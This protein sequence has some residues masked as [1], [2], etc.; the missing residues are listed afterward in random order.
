MR[1]LKKMKNYT[2]IPHM[3]NGRLAVHFIWDQSH[4]VWLA[5]RTVIIY[6]AHMTSEWR[7]ATSPLVSRLVPVLGHLPGRILDDCLLPFATCLKPTLLRRDKVHDDSVSYTL[8]S[9]LSS[10]IR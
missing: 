2:Q 5:E 9:L 4:E 6:V 10:L 3:A 1:K 7:L 8:P